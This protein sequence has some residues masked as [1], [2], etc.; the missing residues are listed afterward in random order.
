MAD[1]IRARSEAQK[2]ERMEEIKRATDELFAQQSYHSITLSSIAEKLGWTRAM[3]YK[4]VTTK[5]DIFLEL[6]GDKRDDYLA[7][8]IAAYPTGANYSMEVL[9]EVWS[10][11]LNSHRDYL[12]YSDILSTIIETNVSVERLAEFKM[13]YYKNVGTLVQQ[14]SEN[15]HLSLEKANALLLSV[16]Y[17]SVGLNSNCVENPLVQQALKIAQIKVP[18]MNFRKNMKEYILMCLHWYCSP[19]E[20]APNTRPSEDEKR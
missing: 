20:A 8:M 18:P 9:A 3:L 2:A 4:Y 10:G 7:A 5:E 14:L 6:N 17:Y 16:Y 19:F 1:Y 15:L 12:R 11:I 13:T